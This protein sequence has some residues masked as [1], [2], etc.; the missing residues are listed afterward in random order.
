VTAV[1]PE[2]A[3]LLVSDS[4]TDGEIDWS[5][6]AVEEI[7]LNDFDNEVGSHCKDRSDV[8]IWHTTGRSF[9]PGE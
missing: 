5:D 2:A 9:F 1:S 7:D 4:V 8:A 3:C 6:S